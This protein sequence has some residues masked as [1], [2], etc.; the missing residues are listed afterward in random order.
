VSPLNA[1]IL[2]LGLF[3]LGL[4]LV[5]DNLKGLCSGGF[6]AA[7][8]ATAGRPALQAGLGVAAGALMQSA[9]AVTFICVSMVGAGLLQTS[10]AAIV[11]L[12]SNVGLTALA[13]V[14]TLNIHP[15]VALIVGGSGIILGTVRIRTWQ[16]VAGAM[17]GLGL[18]LFGLEQMGEGAAPIKD[19]AWFHA[20]ISMASKAPVLGFAVGVLVAAILQS[21]TG[22]V[23][24]IIALAGAG[25]LD[26]PQAAVLIYGT[27][28]GAIVLR[29]VLS[30]GLRNTAIRLVRFEDFFCLVSGLLMLTLFYLELAG[31]PLIL[32]FAS[33]LAHSIPA[34]LAVIFLISNLL[35]AVLLLPWLNTISSLL[36]KLW[37]DTVGHT[38]GDPA[39]ISSQAL[40]DP[41]TAM[42]LL[43]RELARLTGMISGSQGQPRDESEDSGPP[44]D[45]L[46]LSISIE[47]FAIKL[48]SRSNLNAADTAHL[49]K[50]RA[51]LSGIRHV[52]DAMRSF[53]H[54][55]QTESFPDPAIMDM[56]SALAALVQDT[57]KAMDSGNPSAA[58]A[59][60]LK[61]KLHGPFMEDLK[62]RAFSGNIADRVIGLS[63][64]FEDFEITAWTLHRLV[65][66]L[67]SIP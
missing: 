44:P 48:A 27:N 56:Q 22:S 37:P 12:W 38:P 9:T 17:L 31:I 3:F 4:R 36:R 58:T 8:T 57:A 40:A 66:L 15:L 7:I 1:L 50:L 25:A 42:D 26:V 10:A 55:A 47:K 34:Q 61:T 53:T 41:S 5:S 46:K 35:P 65:K 16:T 18:I 63:A 43:R 23:M 6:R 13:F 62:D 32:A 24:M 52:E 54:R 2:G 49:H 59:L 19:A 20:I 30:S 64:L 51:V 60:L 11:I 29:V 45:F 33:A 21:N 39:F 67:I 28:L 14:A